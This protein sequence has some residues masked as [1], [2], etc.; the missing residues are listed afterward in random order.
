M[1]E[2]TRQFPQHPQRAQA[3]LARADCLM[4]LAALRRAP[5]GG[6]DRARISRAVAA[7]ERVVETW[8]RDS[9][10]LAESR[11]KLA[12]ALLD[13]ASGESVADA[14]ATRREVRQ[15][16][17]REATDLLSGSRDTLGMNGRS[18]VSRTLLLLGERCEAD[19]DRKEA[20]A[21]YRLLR[22]LNAGLADSE[23][24]LPGKALAESKLAELERAPSNPTK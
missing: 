11:H 6:P 13:R 18:W 20:I 2:L 22:D 8:S 19:G 3:E 17:A 1:D 24:R 14:N 21:A 9:D 7:Y 23:S 4:G 12:Q 15:L 5:N 16:L 10:A